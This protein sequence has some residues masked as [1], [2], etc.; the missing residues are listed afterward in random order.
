MKHRH[1]HRAFLLLLVLA[2]A[3]CSSVS[4]AAPRSCSVTTDS[5]GPLL[6]CDRRSTP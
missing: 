5:I 3:G 2:V 1:N 4:P 6:T